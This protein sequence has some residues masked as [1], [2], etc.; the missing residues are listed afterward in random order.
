MPVPKN[1][2]TFNIFVFI[3]SL[4]YADLQRTSGGS[5]LH[6]KSHP[7]KYSKSKHMFFFPTF[8]HSSNL[9]IGLDH[10][11]A[12][13][14]CRTFECSMCFMGQS[15]YALTTRPLHLWFLQK[16]WADCFCCYVW[17]IQQPF[18]EFIFQNHQS[19]IPSW[20]HAPGRNP[21]HSTTW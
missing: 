15:H 12:P 18:G 4:L 13:T 20:L 16:A 2:L 7:K 6:S 9:M 5:S 11:N 3:L 21:S 17:W 1:Y 14:P 19:T 10:G 8:D